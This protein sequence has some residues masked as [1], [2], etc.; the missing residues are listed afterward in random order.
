MARGKDKGGNSGGG[1]GGG[2]DPKEK[3]KTDV[4]RLK[5]SQAH[6]TDS[7][8]QKQIQKIIDNEKED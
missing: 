6:T 5:E 8:R 7:K 2:E 1:G 3:Q 4:R